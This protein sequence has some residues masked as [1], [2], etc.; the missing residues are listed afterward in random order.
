MQC[1]PRVFVGRAVQHRSNQPGV[2]RRQ[3]LQTVAAGLRT[4][5]QNAGFDTGLSDSHILPVIIGDEARTLKMQSLLAQDGF[6]I[7]A[8]RPPT[9]PTGT[10]R[11]RLSVHS[12]ITSEVAGQLVTALVRAR[13]LA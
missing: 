3:H 1:Y 2:E 7:Q 13:S 6:L 12:G 4:A 8:V 10:A 9:V 11:L 5:L